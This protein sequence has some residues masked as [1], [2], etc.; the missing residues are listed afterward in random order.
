[1]ILGAG[2]GTRLASIGLSVPKVLVDIDERP[3]LERQ[4]EYLGGQGIEHVVVNAHHRAEQIASFAREYTG[5][6]EVTV[7]SEP[8]L[9]GTAG[10]VRNA[11]DV[12]GNNAFFVLYGDVVVHEP[13]DPVAH[14]HARHGASA[15]L[16]VY[17]TDEVEGKGAVLVDD[18][19]WVS[20]FAEKQASNPRRA[21]VNAG[22]Y[23]LEPG[24]VADLP[25][26]VELDFGHDVF[27]AAI[28]DGARILAY[29]LAEPVIDVGTP[30]G[31]A[32]ARERATHNS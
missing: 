15:T 14:A 18:H 1:M 22:L 32:L 13:L 11:L 2:R 23:L 19:G 28:A 12:I 10:G 26:R 5:P 16:T 9:L 29:Q 7:V 20:G 25:P 6:V 17:E 30:E 27:P 3:L 4:L 31:L 8:S 24:F 21:L